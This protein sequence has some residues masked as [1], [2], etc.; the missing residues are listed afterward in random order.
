MSNF[1]VSVVRFQ[2]T[3]A[4]INFVLYFLDY[5]LVAP[6]LP[7]SVECT[8][9]LIVDLRVLDHVNEKHE[10]NCQKQAIHVVTRNVE[11]KETCGVRVCPTRF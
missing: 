1:D 5:M 7:M 8:R 11:F 3:H 4:Y 2:C 10:A 6:M 9:L